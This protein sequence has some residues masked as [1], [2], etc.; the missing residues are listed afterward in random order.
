MAIPCSVL[1]CFINVILGTDFL[2][3]NITETSFKSSEPDF[4]RGLS[5]SGL[6]FKAYI[7][8]VLIRNKPALRRASPFPSIT[9]NFLEN[10][11]PPQSQSSVV[12]TAQLWK[13]ELNKA[14]SGVNVVEVL[15]SNEIVFDNLQLDAL[16]IGSNYSLTFSAYFLG[17][18]TVFRT[19]AITFIGEFLRPELQNLFYSVGQTF[20]AMRVQMKST[21]F[22][23]TISPSLSNNVL[24]FEDNY[25]SYQIT[26]SEGFYSI[27]RVNSELQTKLADLQLS[28]NLISF[29]KVQDKVV[30]KI[31]FVGWRVIFSASKSI[32]NFLGFKRDIPDSR[33]FTVIPDM[34]FVADYSRQSLPTSLASGE[35]VCAQ[36]CTVAHND[37][38]LRDKFN[39]TVMIFDVGDGLL[40]GSVYGEAIRAID[41]GVALGESANPRL[42]SAKLSEVSP[43][44]RSLP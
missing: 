35:E 17:R 32:G 1:V 16:E 30:I 14:L 18:T 11:S 20:D 15:A 38:Q 26:F 22:T 12:V 28:V 19:N 25:Q 3:T 37:I 24:S 39:V 8:A 5:G 21:D 43:G 34:E 2:C 31:A 27:D 7:R 41:S 42:L 36:F 23:R 29:T 4:C 6:E 10:G 13:D 40:K 9:F 44:A 33:D